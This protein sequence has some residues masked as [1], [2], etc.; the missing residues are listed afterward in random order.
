MNG[1]S[2]LLDTNVVIGLFRGEEWA[3]SFI[4]QA[5]G[6]GARLG[7]SVVTRMELLSFPDLESAEED[8]I[9]ELLAIVEV[10]PLT[11]V[12]EKGAIELRKRHRFKLPDAIV[13][14][15]ALAANSRL[16]SAD[17]VFSRAEPLHLLDPRN[18]E[19]IAEPR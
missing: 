3:R 17:Q 11:D 6:A 14:A 8:K 13:A 1:P 12:V 9:R 5:Q 4:A 2:Y 16:V 15:S 18:V 19:F 7:V 10:L